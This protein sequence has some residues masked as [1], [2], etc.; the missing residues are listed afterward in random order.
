MDFQRLKNLDCNNILDI[1]AYKGNWSKSM[2]VLYPNANFTLIEP[3]KYSELD[4]WSN[5]YNEIVSDSIKET[6]WYQK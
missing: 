2:R 4:E 1:G 5:V 6:K 3:I